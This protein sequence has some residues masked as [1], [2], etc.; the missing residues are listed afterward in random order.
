MKPIDEDETSDLEETYSECSDHLCVIPAIL[1][2]H[3]TQLHSE[4]VDQVHSERNKE[5]K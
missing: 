2:Y 4:K 1:N 3:Q 5:V